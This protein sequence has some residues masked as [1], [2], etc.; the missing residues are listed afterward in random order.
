MSRSVRLILSLLPV[1]AALS[2]GARA[3]ELTLGVYLPQASFATNAERSAWADKL[4]ADLGERAGVTVRAQVF[5]RREDAVSFAGRVDLLVV[6]GLFAMTQPGEAL[7]H[8]SSAPAL[9]LYALD[10]KNVGGL[11]GKVVGVTDAGGQDGRYYSNVALGGE[12]EAA[13]FFGELRPFKDAQT[14]LSAVKSRAIAGAFAPADHPAAQGLSVVARAGAYPLA[15]ILAP[16]AK[17]LAATAPRL[18]G[19]LAGL[20]LGPLGTL[21]AGGGSALG[22]ARA[23]NGAPR[24]LSSPALVT[25][26]ADQRPAAPPIRLRAKTRVPP[27]ELTAVP[28]APPVLELP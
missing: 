15:V 14:A 26:G 18:A 19:S 4:A 20:S 24:G 22:Q 13:R 27:I 12:L 23:A 6:D 21:S 25:G 10:A 9:A 7:A 5:G 17:K 16:D 3:Q 8:A 1:L 28:L 2:E 11:E